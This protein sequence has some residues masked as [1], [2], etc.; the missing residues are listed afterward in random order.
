MSEVLLPL[1]PLQVVLFP[2]SSLP[3][4]IFEE[5]Y[6]TLIAESIEGGSEFGINLVTEKRIA[7]IGCTAIVRKVVQRFDDGKLDIVVLGKRRYRLRRYDDQK[8]PYLVGWV[9]FLPG[10]GETADHALLGDTIVLYNKLVSLVYKG[11][12]QELAPNLQQEDVSF[13]LVQKAG[14][15]LTQRQLLLETENENERLR[16]LHQYLS[17]VLPKLERIKEIERVI[18]GDGY[19]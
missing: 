3:L 9:E 6:K 11:T 17:D 19:L 1:F 10:S 13:L 18:G 16:L 2:G 7:E 12:V 4:H 15:D 5:R 8:A 14:M